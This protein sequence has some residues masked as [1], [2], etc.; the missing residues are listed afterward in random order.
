MLETFVIVPNFQLKAF[1]IKQ[2][3]NEKYLRLYNFNLKFKTVL[4]WTIQTQWHHCLKKICIY[5]H[6]SD[7]KKF[8]KV[9]V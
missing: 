7:W 9:I 3:G 6:E 8:E 5:W 4:N 1:E 2:T